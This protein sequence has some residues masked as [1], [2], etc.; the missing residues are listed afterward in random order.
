MNSQM[1]GVASSRVTLFS[2]SQEEKTE[3]KF[4][5]NPVC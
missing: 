5:G 4:W 1:L 2:L 3:G